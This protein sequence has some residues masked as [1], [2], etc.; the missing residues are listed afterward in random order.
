[1]GL[2]KKLLNTPITT[3]FYSIVS[4]WYLIIVGL[5]MIVLYWVMKGLIGAG[6]LD[7]AFS[8]FTNAER[9]IKGFAQF[10][11]P[12]ITD[13]NKF[14]QCL[15]DTPEYTGDSTSNDIENIIK[16]EIKDIETKSNED[17]FR[18][19]SP[20]YDKIRLLSPYDMLYEEEANRNNQ[21][22]DNGNSNQN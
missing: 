9:Q 10:C 12:K 1:M 14:M 13:I 11:T 3:M 17:N 4:K 22:T 6:V 5:S 20:Y 18:L 8:A 2:F 7:I 15:M 19:L 21:N 16:G